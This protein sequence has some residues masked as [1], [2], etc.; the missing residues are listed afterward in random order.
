MRGG[1]YFVCMELE[2]TC[3]LYSSRLLRAV[4]CVWRSLRVIVSSDGGV[5]HLVTGKLINYI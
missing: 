5:N 3:C 1:D 2:R 4:R